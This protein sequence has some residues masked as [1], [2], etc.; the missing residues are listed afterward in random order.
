[1][2]LY[3]LNKLFLLSLL[4]VLVSCSPAEQSAEEES[5]SAVVEMTPLEGSNWQLVKMTVM[6]GFE[7]TPDDPGKYVL[8]FRSENRLTGTSDCNQLRGS[9][10]QDE[11]ALRFEP[12][13][14]GR[15][16]CTP[17]SLH[18]NLAL[19]LRNVVKHELQAGH[20][21]LTTDT[22]G[23]ELEFEPRD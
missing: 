14:P 6:G 7:F 8:N 13:N 2:K 17:G 4:L 15:S 10:L 5:L 18:N 23:V 3:R 11:T 9:W 1:M 20:M 19:N 12:F 22:E 21:I 16:L